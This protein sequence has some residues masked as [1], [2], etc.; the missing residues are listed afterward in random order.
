MLSFSPW[1][2]TAARGITKL[3]RV[4]QSW[5]GSVVCLLPRSCS[6][7]SS[8]GGAWGRVSAPPVCLLC[9][10]TLVSP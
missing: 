8:V 4:G 10:V 2:L 1:L 7:L 5:S 3:A 6:G 9:L